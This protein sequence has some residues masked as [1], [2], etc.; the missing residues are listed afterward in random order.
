MKTAT[1]MKASD[2]TADPAIKGHLL[3]PIG[4]EPV[5]IRSKKTG[6]TYDL[7]VSRTVPP[8]T[9]AR[10]GEKSG[11]FKCLVTVTPDGLVIGWDFCGMC[12]MGVR[13]C[14]CRVGP[15]PPGHIKHLYGPYKATPDPPP[16][17]EPVAKS[18]LKGKSLNA[19]PNRLTGQAKSLPKL[20]SLKKPSLED[21]SSI[22]RRPAPREHTPTMEEISASAGAT[23]DDLLNRKLKVLSPVPKGKSLGVNGVGGFTKGTK[24]KKLKSLK[25]KH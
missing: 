15:T 5:K 25:K 23:A 13:A 20:K 4:S 11:K 17:P 9:Y 21:E 24:G 10:V 16:P 2:L 7:K 3:V 12:V 19:S 22:R 8:N 6:I 1:I 18:L 14:V